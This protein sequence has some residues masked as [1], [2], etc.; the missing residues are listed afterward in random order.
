[1]FRPMK[2]PPDED[3]KSEFLKMSASLIYRGQDASGSFGAVFQHCEGG[4]GVVLNPSDT[5]VFC[6]F[7]GDAGGKGV[8]YPVS[9]DCTPGCQ[10]KNLPPWCDPA[11]VHLQ[12]NQEGTCYA[13][14]WRTSDMGTMLERAGHSSSYN[15]VVVDSMFWSEHLPE[16]VEAIFYSAGAPES[17]ISAARVA[18]QRF[19][20]R[21]GISADT[22]P[23]L[24]LDRAN[25]ESP[26]E[27]A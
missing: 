7:G 24:V 25:W 23:L 6:G 11:E 9:D 17:A 4:A 14:P 21:Y 18:H 26:F 1:M 2:P 19:L 8:C 20:A 10:H 12:G 13:R 22:F 15:E 16:A 3:Y 5:R 27:A